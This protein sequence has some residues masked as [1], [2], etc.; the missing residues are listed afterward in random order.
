MNKALVDRIPFTR[1]AT[2]FAVSMILSVGMCAVGASVSDGGN[3]AGFVGGL[4]GLV[5]SLGL[6]TFWL[7][8]LGLVLIVPTWIVLSITKALGRRD[9]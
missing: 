8:A 1:M 4:F 6:I 3:K 5:M 2:V 7:A 9:R